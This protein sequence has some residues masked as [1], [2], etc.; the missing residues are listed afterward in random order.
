MSRA[1][2]ALLAWLAA[3]SSSALAAEAELPRA[4]VYPRAL[5]GGAFSEDLVARL[6]AR[7]EAALAAGGGYR[8]TSARALERELVL[9][10]GGRYVA[11]REERCAVALA[12]QVALRKLVLLDL[13]GGGPGCGAALVFRDLLFGEVERRARS[14]GPCGPEGLEAAVEDLAGRVEAWSRGGGSPERLEGGPPTAW[15]RLESEPAG[16]WAELD[17]RD[18]GRL[19]GERLEV[20]AG[21]HRLVVE[22]PCHQP[23]A[24]DLELAAGSEQ[25]VRLAPAHLEAAL[26]VRVRDL[27]ARRGKLRVEVWLDGRRLGPNERS[28]TVPACARALEVRAPG[29]PPHR[30]VLWLNPGEA[31]LVE[32]D[33]NPWQA[34]PQLERYIRFIELKAEKDL[35]GRRVARCFEPG[36]RLEL[37]HGWLR[38]EFGIDAAGAPVRVA[39]TGASFD[40]RAEER[41]C[42]LLAIDRFRFS[43]DR[44]WDRLGM[45]SAKLELD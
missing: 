8:V 16:L 27:D 2:F 3:L 32:V 38:Y 15:L 20:S 29:F 12:R 17:G 35:L 4:A 37:R 28:Y 31:R 19:R 33:L 18:L 26:S 45:I 30:E 23:A 43:P 6:V 39:L 25:T 9:R 36:R 40:L 5:G 13:A 44:G 24:R 42:A 34:E 10:D 7:L 22:G 21:K 14:P 11:C 1:V 41:R